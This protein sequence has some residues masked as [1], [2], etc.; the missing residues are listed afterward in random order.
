[1]D[2]LGIGFWEL[3]I[4]FVIAMMVFG[5]RRLPEIAA[6][7]GKIVRDIR[8]MSQGLLAEWQ[9]EITVAARLDELDV[10]RKELE[11]A[12]RL[13]SE[14]QQEIGQTHQDVGQQVQKDLVQ[15]K[16]TISDLQAE[17][18]TIAPPYAEDKD[19]LES[20]PQEQSVSDTP[21]SDD[22]SSQAE[23]SSPNAAAEIK[24]HSPNSSTKH[25]L[26]TE[27]NGNSASNP[28]IATAPPT[29]ASKE[30]LND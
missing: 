3:I 21:P 1:M 25:P 19:T 17:Q 30:V 2:F 13:L 9:R 29:S 16:Q 5:P 11:E 20:I 18:R 10:A 22:T 23:N 14:T 15:A 28:E 7:A 12:R 6:K 26:T 4:I 8:G 24:S 27:A